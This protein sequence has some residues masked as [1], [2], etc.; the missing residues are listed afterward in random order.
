[1]AYVPKIGKQYLLKRKYDKLHRHKKESRAVSIANYL[2]NAMINGQFKPGE[3]LKE[4]EICEGLGVSRTP[5]REAFRILQSEGLLTYSSHQGVIV[6]PIRLKDI[7]NIWE[8]RYTLEGMATER[9]IDKMTEEDLKRMHLIENS[10]E[11]LEPSDK[12]NIMKKNA[13]FHMSIIRI[14]DNEKLDKI[15]REIW[16]QIQVIQSISLFKEGRLHKSCA[17][18]RKLLNAF[19]NRDRRQARECMEKHLDQGK[20]YLILGMQF[21]D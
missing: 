1:M 21:E 17:E 10:L 2:R 6:T 3:K 16:L 13:E 7:E 9:A 5:L 8:V 14:A 20:E 15:V 11:A 12:W 4:K 19:E 18:H